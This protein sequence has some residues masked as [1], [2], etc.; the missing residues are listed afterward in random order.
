MGKIHR[1]DEHLANMIAAGEVVERPMAALKELVENALDAKASHIEIRL[2]DGGIE[3]LEVHDDG[4]GMD[5]EDLRQAFERHSTSKITSAFDLF[6]PKTLGFRGEAL[7]SIASVAKV[8]ATSSN[9]HD[10]HQ[11]QIHY[12]TPM[13]F[14]P[15]SRP[16]GTSILVE[17]LFRK[18]PA[19]LKHLKSVAYESS[20][21]V[22]LIEKM[23][24]SH[25]EVAFKLIANETI[26]LNTTGRN[27]LLETLAMTYGNKLARQA[28]PFHVSDHDFTVSGLWIEPQEN[29]ANNKSILVFLNTRLIRYYPLQKAVT[30]AYGSYLPPHRYPIVL[31][32]VQ[33]DPSLAD[34]NVHP[35]KWEVK[36][37][38]EGQLCTLVA[39]HLVTAL[40]TTF[41]AKPL[42]R[43]Q[44]EPISEQVPL[45]DVVRGVEPQLP[46][47]EIQ[48]T[49]SV[50]R[51]PTFP[52]LDVVGQMHGRYIVASD[53]ETLYFIDQHAAKERIN[54]ELLLAQL[55]SKVSDQQELLVPLTL[56][57]KPSFTPKIPDFL[58]KLRQIGLDVET[59]GDQHLVV[60]RVPLWLK[61]GT[62]EAFLADLVERFDE[63][64][65]LSVAS[66]RHA[67]LATTACHRSIRFNQQLTIAELRH[68][69][70]ELSHCQQPY[71]CPHGR[72]TLIKVTAADLWKD[73]DR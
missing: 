4:E 68:I 15:F 65:T 32:H 39:D 20:L 60:R 37:S 48:E 17:G 29:R 53:P 10:S 66:L 11:L 45:F 33:A 38:K 52:V 14:R 70:E 34:V 49:P 51:H 57:V 21:C 16:Q 5:G 44:L 2:V 12:G 62:Q 27:D 59:L 23:A 7:P 25:P 63:E 22:D 46:F 55:E 58:D 18:T 71:H 40:R 41:Q 24:L 73:F 31:L 13:S 3:R 1:L 19:R 30:E 64:R 28:H 26:L 9:G 43:P 72:P 67:A 69:V 56:T 50:Y 42:S 8:T 47:P 6:A 54:F 35:A 36:L 61:D